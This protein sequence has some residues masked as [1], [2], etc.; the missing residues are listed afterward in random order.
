ME[1]NMP[2]LPSGRRVEFSLDRFHALLARMTM[3]EA[4]KT[5]AGLKEPNDLLYVMDV[6]FIDSTTGQPYFANRLAAN[7]ETYAITWTH[8]DQ[9]ALVAWIESDSATYYRA[10]AIANIHGM[11]AEI[12][13]RALPLLQMA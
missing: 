12:E 8:E 3:P 13:E 6:V 7:F 10:E 2:T 5:I 1:N 11:V 4:K 9:D